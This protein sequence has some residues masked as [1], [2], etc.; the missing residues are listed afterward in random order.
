MEKEQTEPCT[1]ATVMRLK[2]PQTAVG[3]GFRCR[4]GLAADELYEASVRRR[5]RIT[6][7]PQAGWAVGIWLCL[8]VGGGE[9]GKGADANDTH[10][11]G[12]GGGGAR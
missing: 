6:I 4:S 1:Q 7:V 11:H 2:W 10:T 8:F 5:H 3:R 12:E 9:S